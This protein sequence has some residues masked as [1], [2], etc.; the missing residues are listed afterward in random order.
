MA[1]PG[2]TIIEKILGKLGDLRLT[3]LIWIQKFL[4]ERSL[5]IPNT[6]GH[7]K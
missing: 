6:E 1:P 5:A 3:L 2:N 7:S 4:R